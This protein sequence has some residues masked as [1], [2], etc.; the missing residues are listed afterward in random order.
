MVFLLAEGKNEP[1]DLGA[2]AGFCKSAWDSGRKDSA[3][4]GMRDIHPR[5]AT[6]SA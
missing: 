4:A 6:A 1:G 3:R 2:G 5:E